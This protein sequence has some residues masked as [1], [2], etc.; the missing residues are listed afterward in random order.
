MEEDDDDDGDEEE[1]NEATKITILSSSFPKNRHRDNNKTSYRW[2]ECARTAPNNLKIDSLF[3]MCF[4]LFVYGV[5]CRSMGRRVPARLSKVRRV[6]DDRMRAR[7]SLR[8]VE[9]AG[10]RVVRVRSP[11]VPSSLRAECLS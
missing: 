8:L 7:R 4:L 9:P 2:S 3:L 1:E 11:D 5:N 10:Q 6:I